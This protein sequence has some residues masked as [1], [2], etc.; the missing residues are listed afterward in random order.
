MLLLLCSILMPSPS[1]PGFPSPLHCLKKFQPLVTLSP[2]LQIRP[3]LRL[4]P[5]PPHPPRTRLQKNPHKICTSPVTLKVNNTHSAPLSQEAGLPTPADLQVSTRRPHWP[6]AGYT[7][8]G[9]PAN[10]LPAHRECAGLCP[11]GF[12]S[13]TDFPS[14]WKSW[15]RKNK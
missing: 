15:K 2:F 12:G 13:H 10:L 7:S 5:T 3:P 9:C 4:S 14:L 11:L 8:H 1:V 6:P